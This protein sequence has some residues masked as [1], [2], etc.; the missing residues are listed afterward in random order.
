MKEYSKRDV[1]RAGHVLIQDSIA[2][3]NPEAFGGAMQ[4]LSYWRAW[5][6]DSLNHAFRELSE[7]ARKYDA[8]AVIAKRL[9]RAASIVRK[10]KRFDNMNL[11][12]MQDIGGCRAILAN[13]KRVQKLVRELKRKT[14]FRVRDYIKNPKEDGYRSIHLVSNFPNG[15]GG[16]ASVEIQVRTA[17]QH[18]WATAVEIIDLF[19]GQAIKANHGN[20]EWREFFRCASD[21]LAFI[22]DIPIY[23]QI[24]PHKL[25]MELFRRLQ[26]DSK[27]DRQEFIIQNTEKLYVLESRLGV[28]TRFNAYAGSLKVV[29][30]H[31]KKT[32]VCGYALLEINLKK[33]QVNSRIY[34]EKQ[35]S[36]STAAYLEAEKRAVVTDGLIVALVSTDAVGGIK[37]AYP[38]YFADASLFLSYI[39]ASIVAYR[40]FNQSDLSRAFK[41]IF[42]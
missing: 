10:L 31:L 23:N 1:I 40:E 12:T 28:L 20:T 5:H 7:T 38:N 17:A 25:A 9:K 8:K 42:G 19:A 21:Q 30:E 26:D 29:D 14:N 24:D 27:P 34:A 32:E 4:V 3:T 36:A 2:E 41:R 33:N 37:E 6:E 18:A 11:R 39:S 13:E 16:E 15:H 35:F 22:E